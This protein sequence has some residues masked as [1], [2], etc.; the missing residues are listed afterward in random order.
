V[1]TPGTG[2]TL[3]PQGDSGTRRSHGP[4]DYAALH[5]PVAGR[6]RHGH[7][8]ARRTAYRAR[9]SARLKR[10]SGAYFWRHCG[11]GS[12]R[13]QISREKR[14]ELTGIELHNSTFTKS[15]AHADLAEKS[16]KSLEKLLSFG[17]V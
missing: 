13:P 8:P 2:S 7:P 9:R 3:P 5:A 10:R 15:T 11:D 6:P 4:D 16:L 17:P 14:V 1:I 12:L